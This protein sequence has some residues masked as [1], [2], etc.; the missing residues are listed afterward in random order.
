MNT[1][2]A[3]AD[4]NYDNRM[5]DVMVRSLLILREKKASTITRRHPGRQEPTMAVAKASTGGENIM[6]HLKKDG[7]RVFCNRVSCSS[8]SLLL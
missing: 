6:H 3:T 1:K 8:V 4:V 5:V 2:V 7:P